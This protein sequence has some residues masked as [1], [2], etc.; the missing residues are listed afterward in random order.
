MEQK[1][2]SRKQ[3]A[4]YLAEHGLQRTASTLAKYATNGGG[5]KFR[6]FGARQVLYEIADLD[7]WVSEQL[8]A[9][10]VSTSQPLPS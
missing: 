3:A 9:P 10:V 4:E 6:K 8:S 1:Y 5:P 7:E 2:L